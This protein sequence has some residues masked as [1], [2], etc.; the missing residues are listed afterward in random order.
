MRPNC[1]DSVNGFNL[2]QMFWYSESSGN[3]KM[4]EKNR[5]FTFAQVQTES[6]EFPEA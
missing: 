5:S 1:N 3:E 4:G 2:N 6:R